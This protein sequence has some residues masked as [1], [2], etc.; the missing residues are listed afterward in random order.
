MWYLD[1]FEYAEFKS[2]VHFFCCW[3]ETSFLGK[4]GPKNQNYQFNL[5]FGTLTN[6][7]MENS[8]V[9]FTFSVLDWKLFLGNFGPKIKIVSLSWNLIPRLIWTCRI[10]WWRSLFLFYSGNTHFGKRRGTKRNYCLCDIT[11][12][13]TLK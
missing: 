2:Y 11:R 9:V 3:P 1:Y 8:I 5:N 10:Q 13:E 4:F 12:V 6:S 7:N